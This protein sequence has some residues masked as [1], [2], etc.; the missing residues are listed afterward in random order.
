VPAGASSSPGSAPTEPGAIGPGRVVLLVGP[1]GAGKDAVLHEARGRLADD[2]RFYFPRR[3]VTREANAAEDHVSLSRAAFEERLACGGFALDWQ[4]HGLC[5]GIPADVDEAVRAGRTVA[6]N[7]SRAAVQTARRRFS[8]T[9]AVLIDA[10]LTLRAARLAA[11]NREGPEDA[12]A[13]LDRVVTAF[14][15]ADADLVIDNGG[16]LQDAARRLVEWLRASVER[17][18]RAQDRLR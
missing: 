13:R 7:A 9:A 4:A 17:A 5:Y 18:P 2:P 11:R 8:R 1:S 15:P 10:P 14:S 12:V 6:F 16:A 3:L